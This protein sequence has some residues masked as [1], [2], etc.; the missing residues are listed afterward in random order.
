L[1]NKELEEEEEEDED[2]D[3]DEEGSTTDLLRLRPPAGAAMRA[4]MAAEALATAAEPPPKILLAPCWLSTLLPKALLTPMP[5]IDAPACEPSSGSIKTN[6]C[7]ATVTLPLLVVRHLRLAE[8][9][10]DRRP[11]SPPAMAL[12]LLSERLPVAVEKK[13]SLEDCINRVSEK[14]SGFLL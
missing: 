7:A 8:V 4:A 3:E 13:P 14:E 2:E 6:C 10:K 11:F 5:L 12:E 1:E 9:E